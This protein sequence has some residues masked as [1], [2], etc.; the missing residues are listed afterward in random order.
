MWMFTDPKEPAEARP[1]HLTLLL[2]RMRQGD[3]DAAEEAVAL[4]YGELHDIA[5]RHMRHERRGHTLQTTALVHEAYLRLA[6]AGP[7]EVQNRVHFFALAS[8]Q[9]RRILI[10]HA[11]L[12]S[13][14]K[15]GGDAI[16]TDLDR[17]QVG[18]EGRSVDV[19]ML[20]Q[21][22]EDLE[23][24]EPRAARLVELRYFGGYTDQEA[25]EVLGVSFATARRD[26]E[27]ARAWL[28]DR[29]NGRH[30]G[31]SPAKT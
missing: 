6:G 15:R 19:L 12:T 18:V 28:F 24:L 16:R 3:P 5:S 1:S 22:L 27:F 2:N 14:Q 29:M 21:A 9:M 31:R 7:L 25:A 13:A 4:V 20:D 17:V 30:K 8:Q 23:Q 10:D 11:R 26:W